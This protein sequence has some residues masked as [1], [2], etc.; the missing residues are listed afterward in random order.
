MENQADNRDCA[1]LALCV[2][3]SCLVASA[4]LAA[5]VY[6]CSDDAGNVSFQETACSFDLAQD[7]IDLRFEHSRELARAG[8][9]QGF[10]RFIIENQLAGFQDSEGRSPLHLACTSPSA[11]ACRWAVTQGESLEHRDQSGSNALHHAAFAGSMANVQY[12]IKTGLGIGSLDES[13][14]SVLHYSIRSGQL[15]VSMQLLENGSDPNAADV[16]GVT[17]LKLAVANADQEAVRLLI[18]FGANPDQNDADTTPVD[19]AI[20]QGRRDMLSTLNPAMRRVVRFGNEVSLPTPVNGWNCSTFSGLLDAQDKVLLRKHLEATGCYLRVA[21]VDDLVGAKSDSKLEVFSL[22]WLGSVNTTSDAQR[23]FELTV[24]RYRRASKKLFVDDHKHV[25][26]LQSLHPMGTGDDAIVTSC[27]E[28]I[29]TLAKRLVVIN[30]CHLGIGA[31]DDRLL[32]GLKASVEQ[33]YDRL[34]ALNT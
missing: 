23:E 34:L 31:A 28:I 3:F 30:F 4:S 6:R 11:G 16:Q 9:D 10:I 18:R 12:L 21:S 14:A 5:D 2:V 24:E 19:V 33:W 1:V 27:A 7:Q 29:T 25:G 17:P 15:E 8:D 22:D 26:T 13:G 32:R 20:E